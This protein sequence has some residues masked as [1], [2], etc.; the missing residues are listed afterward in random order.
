MST[1]SQI[2]ANRI[3]ALAS[4]GPT[5]PEGKARVSQNAVSTG[6]F[7]TRDFFRPEE[8]AEY[9]QLRADLWLELCPL[10]VM[11]T[12]QVNE[13]VTATWRLRRCGLLEAGLVN[14]DEP[15]ALATQKSID[16]ARIQS[17]GILFR[18][19]AELRRLRKPPADQ[20][21]PAPG[22]RPTPGIQQRLAPEVIEPTT[23]Q[24]QSLPETTPRSAPCPC[25]SGQK[26]KRCCGRNAPP[27]LQRAA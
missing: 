13:I 12:T 2:H 24:T 8:A 20:P 26:Y 22:T 16:R 5:T 3:N 23:E 15:T 21:R 1:E 11:E 9:L 25:N 18:A 6:L 19:T 4:T 10:T 27:A 17:H 7:T 14:M